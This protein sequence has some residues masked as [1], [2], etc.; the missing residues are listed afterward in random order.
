[1]TYAIEA[2]AILSAAYVV[3]C[4]VVGLWNYQPRPASTEAPT[5][6]PD[7]PPSIAD[8][9]VT[10]ST[11]P[12]PEA[13]PAVEVLPPDNAEQHLNQHTIRQLKAIA[14]DFNRRLG[15]RH[16]NRVRNIGRLT[17]AALIEALLPRYDALRLVV[18]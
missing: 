3:T 17:K 18:G 15:Q 4:F 6:Q 10:A 11:E 5:T 13:A 7:A 2:T 1:M 9:P 16:P 8:E 14:T 12:Q